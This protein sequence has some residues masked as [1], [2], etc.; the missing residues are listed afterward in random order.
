AR[1]RP[2]GA[3]VGA[4]CA[5]GGRAVPA[6]GT[7]DVVH[8]RSSGG[9]TMLAPPIDMSGDWSWEQGTHTSVEAARIPTGP[10]AVLRGRGASTRLRS[11]FTG[12]VHHAQHGDT[13]VV[14]GAPADLL[15]LPADV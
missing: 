11:P 1:G 3:R 13:H 15:A 10:L 5:G 2:A 14:V 9:M 6:R 12:T 7:S 4:R 8:R